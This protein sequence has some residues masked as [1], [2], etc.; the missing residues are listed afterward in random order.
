MMSDMGAG[1][2][3]VCFFVFI[4]AKDD[5][6]NPS[7]PGTDITHKSAFDITPSVKNGTRYRE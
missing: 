7:T 1:N 2:A 5:P 3:G 6:S 4:I